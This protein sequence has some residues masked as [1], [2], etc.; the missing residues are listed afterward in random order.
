MRPMWTVGLIKTE[1][2]QMHLRCTAE[3]P[4]WT[5]KKFVVKLKSLLSCENI[6]VDCKGVTR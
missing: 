6:D 3:N 4:V 1:A 5:C 2:C